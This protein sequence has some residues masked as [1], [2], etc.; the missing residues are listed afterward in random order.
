[1][2]IVKRDETLGATIRNDHGKI[3]IARL[4][5]GGVAARSGCIQEG[6]RILEVNGL[7]A[8]DLSVDDVARILNRVDKGSV[9][10]KLVPADMST[11]TEN[12]TPHVY[13]RALFDYKGKEDSRHPCPEVALSFNIGDILELLACNDDHWWQ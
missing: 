13:L 10:L 12:G 8:S 1:V 11:R 7:P 6:D 3:Y 5:A 4:I 2:R 9:S